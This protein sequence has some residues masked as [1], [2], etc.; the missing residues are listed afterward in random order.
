MATLAAGPNKVAGGAR[1][2]DMKAATESKLNLVGWLLFV[3]SALWFIAASVRA[4]D[5]V[6]LLGGV[7][8]LLGCIVFLIPCALRMR[9]SSS[10]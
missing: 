5:T 7:F 8:F 3:V 6:S 10:R 2:Q 4:G 9:A 1:E